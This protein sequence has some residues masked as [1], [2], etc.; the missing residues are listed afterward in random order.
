MH[1]RL[2]VLLLSLLFAVQAASAARVNIPVQTPA[3][4]TAPIGAN[5]ADM[6]YTAASV[7]DKNEFISTGRE[8]LIVLNSDDEAQTVTINSVADE[9][10]RVGDITGYS[11]GIGET[12]VF[13]PFPVRGWR[14]SGGKIYLEATDAN[15]KFMVIRIPSI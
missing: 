9:L 13:G 14:N 3:K 8:L 12:A 4:L 10:G 2:Y 7:T 5:A 11:V 15:V 1:K 6:T